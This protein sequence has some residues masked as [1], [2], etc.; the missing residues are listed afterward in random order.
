MLDRSITLKRENRHKATHALLAHAN[1]RSLVAQPFVHRGLRLCAVGMMSVVLSASS[2]AQD[3][4]F[5]GAD[6]FGAEESAETFGDTAPPSTTATNPTN[7][8]P[9]LVD[10]ANPVTQMLRE[11]PPQGLLEIGR[12]ALLMYRIEEWA[13]LGRYLDQLAPLVNSPQ[14]AVALSNTYGSE[15]WLRLSM[16]PELSDAQRQL[17]AKILDTVSST[18]TAPATI[19][20]ALLSLNSAQAV[21]RKRAALTLQESGVTG[22]QAVVM[23]LADAKI[24]ASPIVLDLSTPMG[25][26]V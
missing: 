4:P 22:L 14:A 25:S 1:L 18:K 2:Y 24:S 10:E 26:L 8:L 20:Q 5:G 3:D 11:D 16:R 23:A 9:P 17:A 21:E 13:E 15:F 19:E 7:A 12:A 6:A